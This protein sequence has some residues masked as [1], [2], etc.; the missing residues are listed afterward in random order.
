MTIPNQYMLH[1]Y[2]N[3]KSRNKINPPSP[4][5]HAYDV[6]DV[7]MPTLTIKAEIGTSCTSYVNILPVTSHNIY[8]L[9]QHT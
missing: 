9:N 1:C 4:P 2:R 3:I 7:Y 5:T 8:R 6:H